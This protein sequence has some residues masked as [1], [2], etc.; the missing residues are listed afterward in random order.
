M[1]QVAIWCLI[2]ATYFIGSAELGPSYA[3]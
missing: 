1:L 3:I 2:M